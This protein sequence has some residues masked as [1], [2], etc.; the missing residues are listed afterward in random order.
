MRLK[1][2]TKKLVIICTIGALLFGFSFAVIDSIVLSTCQQ[3]YLFC[4]DGAPLAYD[5]EL[6]MLPTYYTNLLK[7]FSEV[8]QNPRG[9]TR[10]LL[11]SFILIS[12]LLFLL[13]KMLKWN[14]K[15]FMSK[16]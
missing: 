1:N 14:E 12:P 3:P 8:L 4:G 15:R 10:E 16:L 5:F 2:R 11:L 7:S 9:H 6:S 13:I